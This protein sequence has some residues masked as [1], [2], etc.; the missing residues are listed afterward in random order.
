MDDSVLSSL[1][2]KKSNE[3]KVSNVESSEKKE[4]QVE[5]NEK[6]KQ[7]VANLNY[8]NKNDFQNSKTSESKNKKTKRLEKIDYNLPTSFNSELAE[9][10]DEQQNDENNSDEKVE[11][12]ESE[13]DTNSKEFDDFFFIPKGSII[14]ST[15][16]GLLDLD[17]QIS[18]DTKSIQ[19]EIAEGNL[20]YFRISILIF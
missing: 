10:E 4:K 18:E 15:Q 3:E 16:K 19:D 5:S 2:D 20:I 8:K 11:K 13:V 6:T 7:A 14:D 9:L 1:K 12:Q 17:D